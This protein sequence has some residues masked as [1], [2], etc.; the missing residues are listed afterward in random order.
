MILY[1]AIRKND[2]CDL[3]QEIIDD[4]DKLVEG[5]RSLKNER[6][7]LREALVVATMQMRDL[8]AGYPE[9]ELCESPRVT[10]R[11]LSRL[12]PNHGVPELP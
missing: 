10:F 2:V 5:V 12:V 8:I 4:R 9:R 6:F 1:D 11:R 3:I 7:E